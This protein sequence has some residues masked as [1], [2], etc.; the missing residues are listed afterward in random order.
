[1]GFYVQA[2]DRQVNKGVFVCVDGLDGKGVVMEALG[3]ESTEQSVK[4]LDLH[5]AFHIYAHTHY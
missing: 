5:Y 1:M 3:V 2:G 4:R